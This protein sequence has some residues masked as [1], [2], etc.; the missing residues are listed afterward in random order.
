VVVISP[1]RIEP[2]VLHSAEVTD[3]LRL[4]MLA[5]SR[6]L[7]LANTAAIAVYEA[8]RQNGFDGSA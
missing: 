5:S 1:H 4:P 3:R 8:W 2:A 7:N 6:S